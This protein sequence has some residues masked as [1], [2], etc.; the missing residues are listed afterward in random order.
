MLLLMPFTLTCI[1]HMVRNSLA[2]LP[3]KDRKIVAA[4]LKTVYHA[5]TEE[6]ALQNLDE[7]AAKWDKKYPVAKH[8]SA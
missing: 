7:F 1:V 6:T 2:Y 5:D 3:W 8:D 4:E